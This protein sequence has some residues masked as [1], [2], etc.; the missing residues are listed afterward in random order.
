MHKDAYLSLKEKYETLSKTTS[1]LRAALGKTLSQEKSLSCEIQLQKVI[2]KRI[3]RESNVDCKGWIMS[4]Y[5]A[6]LEQGWCCFKVPEEPVQPKQ[7]SPSKLSEKVQIEEEEES[8]YDE[9]LPVVTKKKRS[10]P[11]QLVP[12][13]EDAKRL[14]HVLFKNPKLIWPFED[15]VDPISLNIPDYP[16]VVKRPMDIGTVR[17][18]LHEGY[19]NG[20]IENFVKDIRR[21]FVNATIYNDPY[22]QIHK[23][24]IQCSNVFE[25]KLDKSKLIPP[26]PPLGLGRNYRWKQGISW[27]RATVEELVCWR[28]HKYP[29][30][31]DLAR[32]PFREF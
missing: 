20:E 30:Q 10:E 7:D 8:D 16:L 2:L 5:E 31:R 24:A 15:P 17:K 22:H 6:S 4:D 18:R 9:E 25:K 3:C 29:K 23:L 13:V 26:T 11:P 21:V 19:Y 14:L 28:T 27:R 32:N 12:E 1:S